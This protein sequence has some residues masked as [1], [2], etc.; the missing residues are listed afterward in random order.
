MDKLLAISKTVDEKHPRERDKVNHFCELVREIMKNP[1]SKEFMANHLAKFL[2]L[3]DEVEKIAQ[4]K[5]LDA[6]VQKYLLETK[7]HAELQDA[8]DSLV[9]MLK[10]I[11]LVR[12][13]DRSIREQ[14]IR[15]AKILLK[16]N[17]S[18]SPIF[19]FYKFHVFISFILEREFKNNMVAKERQQCFKFMKAWLFNSPKTFPLLFA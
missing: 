9:R 13:R 11:M 5:R 7:L 2:S 14:S 18:L 19:K 15:A 8:N 3:I 6:E 12:Q 17:P 10:E 1:D 16:V 4:D